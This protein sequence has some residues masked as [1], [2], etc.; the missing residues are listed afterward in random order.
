MSEDSPMPGTPAIAPGVEESRPLGLDANDRAAQRQVR[1]VLVTTSWDDGHILDHCTAGLLDTYG[2][3]G[4][5]YIAPFNVEFQRR[6][7][8][9]NRDLQALAA[10]FEIGGHTLSHANLTRTSDAEAMREIAEGKD[11]L[12]QAIGSTVRSFC[13]PYGR[14]E[15]RHGS[16]AR[17]A[18]FR[19][20]R[21]IR[22]YSTTAVSRPMEA[23]TTIHA[24]QHLSDMPA[25]LRL[26]N[27]SIRKAIDFYRNWDVLAMALFDKVLSAGG[28]YHLWGHSWEIERNKDW[29]RLERV[30]EYVGGRS[31]VQYVNNG[32]TVTETE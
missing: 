11:C 20:A 4:T 5:F 32:D 7:R 31:D 15:K 25:M 23:N 30:L 2:V 26:A 18:G 29:D 13:Y 22:R 21:T 1:P 6:V 24:C 19:Y 28:V 17:S 16:M 14:Y 3:Q 10:D 12:E 9:R 27:G 8:L